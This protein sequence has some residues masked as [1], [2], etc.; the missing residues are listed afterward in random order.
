MIYESGK[1]NLYKNV[2]VFDKGG[3]WVRGEFVEVELT[4][5]QAT[6]LFNDRFYEKFGFVGF[7]KVGDSDWLHSFLYKD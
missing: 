4:E 1:Y 5:A 6:N 3:K 7:E 2:D